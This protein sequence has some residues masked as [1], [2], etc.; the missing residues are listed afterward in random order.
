MELLFLLA[1]IA[2]VGGFVFWLHKNNRDTHIKTAG[3]YDAPYKVEPPTK[4]TEAIT[5]PPPGVAPSE[6]STK[7]VK[8]H[9]LPAPVMVES[10]QPAKKPAAKKSLA[11]NNTSKKPA[12]MSTTK[13]TRRSKKSS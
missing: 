1:I 7:D 4:I 8:S 12:A 2:A 3:T 13:S 6:D 10:K 9:D 5:P 11:S